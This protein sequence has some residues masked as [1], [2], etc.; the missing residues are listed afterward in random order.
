[1]AVLLSGAPAYSI[2]VT[3]GQAPETS[4]ALSLSAIRSARESLLVNIYEFS[5][6]EIADAVQAKILEGVHVEI[7][8]EGQPVGGVSAAARGIQ[9]Q[10]L[11]A[12]QRM[13][14]NDRYVEMSA[15]KRALRRFRYDHAK[16]LVVDG[17]SL[18]ISSE[19]YSPNGHPV[20]GS[21][22]NRGWETFIHDSALAAKFTRMFRSDSDPAQPD[23]QPLAQAE[24][25]A[26]CD[27]AS[28]FCLSPRFVSGLGFAATG[29]IPLPASSTGEEPELPVLDARRADPI[30]S[31]ETSLTGLVR[32]LDSAQRRIDVQQLT[33][34]TDWKKA[35]STS[36]L[37]EALFRAAER[38]VTVRI[39]VNDD[40][41]FLPPGYSRF[42]KVHQMIASLN[43]LARERKL[44]LSGRVANLEVMGVTIIHNKGVLVD[45]D[46][47]LISSINWNE[48]SVMNNR[49]AAVVLT[50]RDINA[51]YSF[52]FEKDWDNSRKPSWKKDSRPA[53]DA[54]Q[55][56]VSTLEAP[57]EEDGFCPATL[58][59][60][61]EVG[62]LDLTTS[63][64]S[65]QTLA[66]SVIQGTFVRSKH[67]E[68]ECLLIE[69][70]FSEAL[71]NRPEERSFMQIRKTA[72]GSLSLELAGYTVRHKL[73]SIRSTQRPSVAEGLRGQFNASVYDNSGQSPKRIGRAKFILQE[74]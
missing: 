66:N 50:S 31:P 56:A 1:M 43:K 52:L 13:R 59:V 6:P 47:T 38:G 32:L 51:H 19:N 14:N 54:R 10:L 40:S 34:S 58:G 74:P 45:D 64:R 49:E 61:A 5:N 67:S 44:P 53:Q 28:L 57:L 15:A 8:Q 29:A 39:L 71:N 35:D 27:R 7:L 48:N 18:L 68:K 16:Y 37:L 55:Q 21:S 22:G 11:S 23:I 72:K 42:T 20:A 24:T 46:K 36:P 65:F 60:T 9:T 69:R 26:L 12:M 62:E 25:A 3:V 33:F 2:P 30:S 70:K 17:K 63:D 41:A 73:F 4:L